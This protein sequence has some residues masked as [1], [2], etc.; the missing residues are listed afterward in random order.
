MK[1]H[2]FNQ[3]GLLGETACLCL[4]LLVFSALQLAAKE[5]PELQLGVAGHAFDH[6]G[7]IQDQ[8]EAAAA[9]GA[10][11]L[12]PSGFGAVGYGGL[13]E[14]DQ[15]TALRERTAGYLRRARTNG[16]QLALG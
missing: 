10:T 11:I 8:A 7:N 4:A 5:R 6:L 13:L 3:L 16:I 15:L 2:L 1:R 14:P 9:S 12:Y